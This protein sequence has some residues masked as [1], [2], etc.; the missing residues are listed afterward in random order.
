[1]T[2]NFMDLEKIP[3]Q[4]QT[5]YA[6]LL[7]R[8]EAREARRSIG[9]AAG[10][11]TTKTVKREDYYYFQ[12]TDPGGAQRQVYIGKKSRE[13][14]QLVE[15]FLSDRRSV[16]EAGEDIQRLCAQIRV[17][18]ALTSDAVSARVLK[19]LADGAFFRL[20]GVLVGTHAFG[21]LGNL[22]GVR[23]RGAA[24]RT[25]DVDIARHEILQVAVNDLPDQADVPK[26]LDRLQM[27]FLPIPALNPKHPS[28]SFA[29]R[30]SS[31]RVDILTPE[32]G[33]PKKGPVLIKRF[34]VA[35]QPLRFLD[36]LIE[37]PIRGAVIDGGGILVN[38][39]QPARFAFHKLLVSQERPAAMHAKS[40]KDLHQA[41]QVFAILCEERPGDVRLAWTDLKS[42]GMGWV[43]RI[44]IG[45]KRIK[46]IDEP[47][48]QRLLELIPDL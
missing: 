14:D 46:K 3:L 37:R 29:I 45:V 32:V 34:N 6:E 28:T 31:L 26:I 43:K 11:F 44:A 5:L 48:C 12:F 41:C 16:Q 19:A 40:E 25:Q 30:K 35:A 36:Y 24:I 42:R 22:L 17:G 9:N 8:L 21:V 10:C 47:V 39:P 18:S 20:E 13:L 38:V 33:R 15:R 7:E 27:G 2:Y 1:M 23:W 4:T